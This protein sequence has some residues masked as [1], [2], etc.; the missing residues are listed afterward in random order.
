MCITT[1]A[2]IPRVQGTHGARRRNM[3]M[4]VYLRR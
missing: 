3:P 4:L 2:G 1:A